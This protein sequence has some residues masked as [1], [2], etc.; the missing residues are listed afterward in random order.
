V[1]P[2]QRTASIAALRTPADPKRATHKLW[3][4]DQ[5]R[6]FEVFQVPIDLLV[7]NVDN[8]RFAAER[9]LVETKLGRPLDP[10]SNPLDDLS[11]ISILCDAP[12]DVDLDKGVAVGTPS[13]DYEA[14][15]DDWENRKQAEPL[16]IR[17]D[18]TVR[19][20]NRRLAMLKRQRA[21][22]KDFSWVDAVILEVD[23]ID[24][25]ELFRMEQ[26]EQLAENFKK[27]YEN[28]N[29]LLALKD[30]ADLEGIVWDD[31]ESLRAMSVRLK[32]YAGRDDAGYA[33]VQ[34][35]AVR[36][37]E[38]YLAH[39]NRPGQYSLATGQVEVFR[40]VGKCLAVFEDEPEDAFEL[41]QAA[42]AF[43]QAGKTYLQLRQL[44][45][46]FGTDR[47]RFRQ[48]AAEVALREEQAGW[49]PDLTDEVIA[50]D[51]DIVTAPVSDDEDVDAEAVAPSNYP[52][53]TVGQAIDTALDAYQASLLDVT[54][55][56][57]QALS[58]LQAIEPAALAAALAGDSGADLRAQ[59]NAIADW[60][61]TVPS[62]D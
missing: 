32:H 2:E 45:K 48:L 61:S 17:P 14:L 27:R 5:W 22:G 62:P 29:A 10:A 33:L 35:Q 59:I 19:N 50:P 13:K 39:I 57:T 43:V 49:T 4:K 58:R 15:R 21:A 7:L 55:Q 16:W 12:L 11:V 25:A 20:G 60:I 36:A 28:L 40:E 23:D 31:P 52:K 46:M 41:V 56:L 9:E 42:F 44:R 6:Y 8:K 47:D 18:G 34:L 37:L 53:H 54:T 51:L 30:A 1:T 3:V 26:R 38:A 24:E